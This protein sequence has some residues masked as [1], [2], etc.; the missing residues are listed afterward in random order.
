MLQ[1]IE[2]AKT[3]NGMTE[4]SNC[5][6]GGFFTTKQSK[7]ARRKICKS[8]HVQQLLD[9]V[10]GAQYSLACAIVQYVW[11]MMSHPSLV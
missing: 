6:F 4:W 5:M 11:I 2:E 1:K 9:L 10:Y 3:G 7:P 8:L